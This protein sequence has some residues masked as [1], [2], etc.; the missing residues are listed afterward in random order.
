MVAVSRRQRASRG[1]LGTESVVCAGGIFAA[2][3]IASVSVRTGMG[4][5][6]GNRLSLADDDRKLDLADT[7]EVRKL[8]RETDQTMK[9]GL[10]GT[11]RSTNVS[12]NLF[13]R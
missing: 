1:E 9:S 3:G 8:I 7:S 4:R 6:S 10:I 5:V 13:S 11:E 12:D 2:V